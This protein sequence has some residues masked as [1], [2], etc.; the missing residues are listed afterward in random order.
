MK[1]IAVICA[2]LVVLLIAVVGC[3]AI[4]DI[5]TLDVSQSIVM[6]VGAA[7][8]LLGVC[9]ALITFILRATRDSTN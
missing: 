3:L 6:K 8:V 1:Q 9:T 2:I 7:I 4:F 5:I